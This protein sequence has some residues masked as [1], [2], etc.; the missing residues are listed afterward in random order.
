MMDTK[1]RDEDE[2]ANERLEGSPMSKGGKDDFVAAAMKGGK[3]DMK[4]M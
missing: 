1:L 4:D 3:D 2:I